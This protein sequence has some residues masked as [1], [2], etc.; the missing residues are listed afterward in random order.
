MRSKDLKR[1]L[2]FDMAVAAVLVCFVLIAS[3]GLAVVG[4]LVLL[5]LVVAG[6]GFVI[7]L[8]R[9]RRRPQLMLQEDS[10]GKEP[11]GMY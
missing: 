7:D 9:G 1:Q 8:A 4:M 3:P 2:L 11:A 5:V 10:R 6:A